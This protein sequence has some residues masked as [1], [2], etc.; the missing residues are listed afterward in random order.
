M[1]QSTFTETP[2]ALDVGA[3]VN[4]LRSARLEWRLA[5]GRSLEPRGRDLPSRDVLRELTTELHGLLFPMR[6]G[7]S[8]LRQESEDFYVGSTSPVFLILSRNQDECRRG[9][10]QAAWPDRAVEH[11]SEHMTSL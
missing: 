7:P 6:L 2:S 1:T 3:I 9:P 8:D 5:R 10:S 4:E 11:Q